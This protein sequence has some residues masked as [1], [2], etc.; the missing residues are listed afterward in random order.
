MSDSHREKV[1]QAICDKQMSRYKQASRLLQEVI[2][3]VES[4][5]EEVVKVFLQAKLLKIKYRQGL[6]DESLD[7]VHTLLDTLN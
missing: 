5:S 4:G 1:T 3:E 7:Q 2:G 6:L